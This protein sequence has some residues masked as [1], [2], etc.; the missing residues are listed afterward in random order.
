L[1]FQRFA[2]HYIAHAVEAWR[3]EVTG[4]AATAGQPEET[5]RGLL[6]AL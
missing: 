3:A 1:D 6:R 2:D 5:L 4:G